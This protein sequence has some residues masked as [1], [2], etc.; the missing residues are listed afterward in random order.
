MAFSYQ[1]MDVY[2]I[3]LGFVD[4]VNSILRQFPCPRSQM[5]EK[6]EALVIEIPLC[7]ARVCGKSLK[8]ITIK[9]LLEVRAIV[10]EI[11]ALIEILWRRKLITDKESE[12]LNE[13]LIVLSNLLSH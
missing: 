10:Y 3:A 6:L 2:H 5:L 4:S 11:Q 1:D 9:D 12:E 13:T 7:L 8:S